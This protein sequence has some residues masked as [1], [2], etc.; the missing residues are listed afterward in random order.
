ML[1]NYSVL[2]T[3]ACGN[4]AMQLF[5]AL[6][7]AGQERWNTGTRTGTSNERK[8]VAGRSRVFRL[9]LIIF[10]IC[11]AFRLHFYVVKIKSQFD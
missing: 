2:L 8:G 6:E 3:S 9:F 5:F 4:G 7:A 10:R 11:R 1:N